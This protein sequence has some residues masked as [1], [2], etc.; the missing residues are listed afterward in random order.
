MSK[1]GIVVI[2]RNEGERLRNCLKSIANRGRAVAYVDS[3]S[4]DGSVTLAQTFGVQTVELDMSIPFTA[5]R[6]R[7][8][9]YA[10]LLAE[11]PTLELVQFVDGDCEVVDGWLE[12][13]ESELEGSARLGAVC[14]RRR[15]RFPE[16]SIYNRLCDI[17]W[18]TPP[19]E[20]DACGGDAMFRVAAFGAVSGYNARLIAGEEPD[21]CLRL[22]RQ[23]WSIRRVDAEMTLHDAALTRFS[24]WWKRARRG[25]HA[26]AE[27]AHLH[28]AG[29]ERH[30]VREAR[31][32][33][34]WGLALPLLLIGAAPLTRGMS[35]TALAAAN[36][37]L[38]AKI[39]RRLLRR[40]FSESDATLYAV[41]CVA[42][43]YPEAQGQ[44]QYHW[45]RLRGRQETL[46][47][48][49]GAAS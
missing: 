4:T 38:A 49:K 17:E 40:G 23:G 33:L 39:R 18:N 34:V 16:A 9:G 31:S 15:E 29:P 20:V 27:G 3:G 6:A 37:L 21:L 12:R 8:A 45:S 43:K 28:G 1:C 14:G 13:A 35:L 2:G 32:G 22:R 47:E 36:L 19:G 44:L 42:A 48:Y 41:F 7:N 5:A 25:G 11:H 26:F 30:W 24:Q 10:A 46:I